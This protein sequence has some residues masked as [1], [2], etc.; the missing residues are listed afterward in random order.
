[1]INLFA[2]FVES[3]NEVDHVR[4]L[5]TETQTNTDVCISLT[6][7]IG[8]CFF[9]LFRSYIYLNYVYLIKPFYDY[10]FVIDLFVNN[11]KGTF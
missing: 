2:C 8:S 11:C 7:F 4:C 5:E 3:P 1:M 10:F 9:L 6:L